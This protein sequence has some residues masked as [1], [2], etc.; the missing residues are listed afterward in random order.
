L[1]QGEVAARY[2]I[3][4]LCLLRS[5]RTGFGVML[6]PMSVGAVTRRFQGE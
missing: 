6:V 5:L 4:S 2:A 3:K 1:I